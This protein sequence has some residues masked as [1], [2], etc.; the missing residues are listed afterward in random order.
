MV[1][2]FQNVQPAWEVVK[3]AGSS[4]LMYQ[5]LII[6]LWKYRFLSFGLWDAI[7]LRKNISVLNAV[8]L[9]TLK[10]FSIDKNNLFS[11]IFI[12][13][14]IKP[15]L[16]LNSLFHLTFPM[17]FSLVCFMYSKLLLCS[18]ADKLVS[19]D[20]IW[21]IVKNIDSKAPFQ[22]Y[23]I[24]ICI[25]TRSSGNHM[26]LKLQKHCSEGQTGFYV[27]RLFT[28]NFLCIYIYCFL[29]LFSFYLK[30]SK[31]CFF[32]F[33]TKYV[34]FSLVIIIWLF[35]FYFNW[36]TLL[37]KKFVNFSVFFFNLMKYLICLMVFTWF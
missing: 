16:S 7:Q 35:P 24:R 36:L 18:V 11:E 2:W 4:I 26:H 14:I 27:W 17:S 1:Q 25:L 9:L 28:S 5:K 3:E 15:K 33:I 21:E 32:I 19:T 12:F 37:C 20:S 13:Y 6:W 29:H 8:A 10:E 31:F 22:T 30:M 34:V 23:W